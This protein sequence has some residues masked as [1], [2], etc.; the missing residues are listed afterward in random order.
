LW[1]RGLDINLLFDADHRGYRLLAHVD[2]RMPSQENVV[3]FDR[4]G[5][6]DPARTSGEV[7]RR[8]GD[9]PASPYEA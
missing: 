3:G 7:W 4:L 2:E 8:P 1:P 9:A 6:D 5:N